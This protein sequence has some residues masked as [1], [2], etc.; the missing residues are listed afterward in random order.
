MDLLEQPLEA[1][2]FRLYSLPEAA[3]PAGPAAWTCLAAV[4]AA[5]AAATGIWRLRAAAPVVAMGATTSGEDGLEPESSPATATSEQARSSSERQ[6]EPASSPSP[7]ETYTAYF[8]DSC[9]VGCC[10]MDDDDDDGDEVLEEEEEDD[11]DEPSERMPFEWEIVRSLPLSPTAAAAAAEVRRYRDSA[12][13]GGSVVRLWNHA[14]GGGVTAA[15]PRRRGR[16]GGV[17]SAF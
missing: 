8:H 14:A 13:L 11:D 12:P 4:L 15:N 9:C 5:A 16:D 6:P 17:V 7:K 2:A 1:V 3:A 10:D